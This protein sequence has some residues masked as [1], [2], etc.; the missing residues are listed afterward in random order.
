MF[1][2]LCNANCLEDK[3]NSDLLLSDV[4]VIFWGGTVGQ[5]VTSDII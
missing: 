4:E 3:D 2:L 1:L 5:V